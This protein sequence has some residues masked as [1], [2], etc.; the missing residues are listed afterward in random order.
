MKFHDIC[1]YED[2]SFTKFDKDLVTLPGFVALDKLIKFVREIKF[3]GLEEEDKDEDY[4][5]QSY[6]LKDNIPKE[7]LVSIDKL[8]DSRKNFF[9]VVKFVLA[10]AINN[11][12]YYFHS[13][14]ITNAIVLPEG[15]TAEDVQKMTKEEVDKL[16]KKLV[17]MING[18][19]SKIKKEEVKEVE[20]EEIKREN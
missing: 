14:K 6:Q 3:Q 18:C 20:A 16:E 12:L 5:I 4:E 17:I 1:F 11:Q 19:K 2:G 13:F 7:V 15:K 10:S 8:V 9:R